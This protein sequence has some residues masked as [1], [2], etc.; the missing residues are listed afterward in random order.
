MPHFWLKEARTNAYLDIT[1][2]SV[3]PDLPFEYVLDDGVV[4][5]WLECGKL[6][7]PLRISDG[8]SFEA[9]LGPN[10]YLPVTDLSFSFLLSLA[11]SSEALYPAP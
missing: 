5:C 10:Q 11:R 7:L 8:P 1:P 2:H 4:D 6:P 9:R 3:S